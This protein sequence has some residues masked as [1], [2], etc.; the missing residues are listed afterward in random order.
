MRLCD[1]QLQRV[2]PRGGRVDDRTRVVAATGGAN[3]AELTT[4]EGHIVHARRAIVTMGFESQAFLPQRLAQLINA[5]VFATEPVE[6]FPDWF[7]RFLIWETAR[8]SLSAN[9]RRPMDSDGR[10]RYPH[11]KPLARDALLDQFTEVIAGRVQPMLPRIPMRIDYRRGELTDDELE[12]IQG[13]REQLEGTIQ[14][15]YGGAHAETHKYLDEFLNTCHN[16]S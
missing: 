9:H 16:Y 3:H 12:Q 6:M 1:A 10:W 8:P 14:R 7:N 2:Q 15:R 4:A 11:S 5:F 13:Q